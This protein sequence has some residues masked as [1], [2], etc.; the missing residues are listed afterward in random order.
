MLVAVAA[1]A[2]DAELNAGGFMAKWRARGGSVHVV[3][4][5]NNCAGLVIPPGKPESERRW[6]SPH[7][8]TAL[9]MREQNASARRLGAKV[10]YMNYCQRQY[11]NGREVVWIGHGPSPKP[12]KDVAG[13]IQILVAMNQAPEIEKVSKLLAGL[14]PDLVLTQAPFD[15]DPEH[16]AVSVLAWQAFSRTRAL[17]GVP[18]RYWTPSTASPGG[19]FDPQYDHIEDISDYYDEKLAL[20][21]CHAS[22]MTV[23]RLEI[24]ATRAAY[25][26]RKIKVKYAEPFRRAHWRTG[27]VRSLA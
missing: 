3:M 2:D 14:K 27:G 1:H 9:R 18:L 20:C 12:P 19:T 26:G 7:A 24:V 25:W 17:K 15:V 22:Q 11:W 4:M 13:F 10:H 21:R 16:H 6:L 23:R 5:T 8:M